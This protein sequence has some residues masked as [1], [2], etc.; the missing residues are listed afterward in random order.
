MKESLTR[1]K[2][3]IKINSKTKAAWNIVVVYLFYS[4]AK[5]LDWNQFRETC[6]LTVGQ[7]SLDIDDRLEVIRLPIK[8]VRL[9]F[10]R[11]SDHQI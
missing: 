8:T 3:G 6:C 11:N 2:N 5:N 1:T 9:A 10:V 7:F 4:E